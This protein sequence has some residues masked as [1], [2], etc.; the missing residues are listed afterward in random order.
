MAHPADIGKNGHAKFYTYRGT[1]NSIIPFEPSY[2][3]NGGF[4]SDTR[5]F[6]KEG[7]FTFWL[8][9]NDANL[10]E[11]KVVKYDMYETKVKIISNS[12]SFEITSNVKD[13]YEVGEK[14]I[15]RWR[16]D[17]DIFGE[18][19]KVRILLFIKLIIKRFP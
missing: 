19:S 18:N 4:E 8:G 11:E 17:K 6:V 1:N 2:D 9:V 7:D 12:Q 15:L 10:H 16:V 3:D 5:H 13:K 14:I